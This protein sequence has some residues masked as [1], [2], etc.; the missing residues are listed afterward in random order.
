[1]YKE[2]SIITIVIALILLL[3]VVTNN[4]TTYAADTLSENL[5]TLRQHI[6]AKNEKEINNKIKEIEDI[7]HNY[8]EVLAYYI[9]HDELEK[10]ETELTTLK[11]SLEVKEY[12]HCIE[13]LDTTI[14][15]LEHIKDKER[16]SIQSIF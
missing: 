2:I 4:Y 12:E 13:N 1:M 11:G 16:F 3:D 8:H 5:N 14:F 10:V 9:E 6:M 7:W 15:I